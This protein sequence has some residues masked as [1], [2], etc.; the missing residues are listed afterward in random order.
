MKVV[1]NGVGVA[2]PTL[3][4]WLTRSGH[5]VTL[6]EQASALRA[7]GYVVDFWGVGYDVAERMGL[8]PRLLELGYQAQE[9]RFVDRSGR[10]AGTRVRRHR[11]G[12]SWP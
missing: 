6:V 3:A 4:W 8:V 7:G 11:Y 1:I 12:S 5:E 2:G 10:T 9:V